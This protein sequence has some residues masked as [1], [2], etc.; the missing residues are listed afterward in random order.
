MA[1]ESFE[2]IVN[3]VEIA[4]NQSI[5]VA[6]VGL[7]VNGASV[8]ILGHDNH[9]HSH[10]HHGHGAHDHNLKAAYLHVLADALTSLL[11]IVA[12]LAAKYAD[13]IWMDPVVGILGAIL[14]ARWSVG[15]LRTTSAVLLDNQASD[16]LRNAIEASIE[17]DRDSQVTDLHVW[18][19]GPDIHNVVVSIVAREPRTPADYAAALPSDLGIAHTTIEVHRYSDR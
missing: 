10:H 7:V 12:L 4:F 18:L 2:R 17:A 3:P 13:L 11:A 1:V 19:I 14:V 8:L 5:L 16:E 9:H 15:L 6:I